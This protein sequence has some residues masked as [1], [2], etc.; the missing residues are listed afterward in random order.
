MKTTK[1][2][3]LAKA[4]EMI[5]REGRGELSMA[6]LAEKVGIRKASLYHHIRSRED[7]IAESYAYHHRK[8]MKH[9]FSINL[10][11]GKEKALMLLYDNWMNIARDEELECF[12]I[13]ILSERYFFPEAREELRALELMLEGSIGIIEG[14]KSEVTDVINAVFFSSLEKYLLTGEDEGREIVSFLS[15]HI[16][17]R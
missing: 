3:I 6:K 7:V 2:E 4:M 16:I 10:R 8:M 9:G 13:A 17:S 11:D 5:A 1:E 12:L 15:T 14:G